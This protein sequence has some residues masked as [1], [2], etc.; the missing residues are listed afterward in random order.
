[1][2]KAV[3]SFLSSNFWFSAII[4]TEVVANKPFSTDKPLDFKY[5]KGGERQG[6]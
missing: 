3:S 5:T 4:Y 6:L 2:L 1:M